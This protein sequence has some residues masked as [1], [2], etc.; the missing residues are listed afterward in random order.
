MLRAKSSRD[1]LIVCIATASQPTELSSVTTPSPPVTVR[2]KHS[3]LNTDEQVAKDL[4]GIMISRIY[5]TANKLFTVTDSVTKKKIMKRTLS[6]IILTRPLPRLFNYLDDC[7]AYVK[8]NILNMKH[9]FRF[10]TQ[11]F[12]EI[13]FFSP[14]YIYDRKF[15]K[16]A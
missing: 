8:N 10:S 7:S 4:N 15:Q 16:T 9:V 2:N 12:F 5:I 11:L 1:I 13:I 3:A 6:V 14:I